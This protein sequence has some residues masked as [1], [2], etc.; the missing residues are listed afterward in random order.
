MLN[1]KNMLWWIISIY[2]SFALVFACAARAGEPVSIDLTAEQVYDDN[3]FRLPGNDY[4][5]TV[6]G[7]GH[8]DDVISRLGV[9]LNWDVPLSLQR[10]TGNAGVVA[11]RFAYNDQLNNDS[12]NM[13]LGW[14][15]EL[16]KAWKGN[17]KWRQEQVLANFS[18]FQDGQRNI[19]T[20]DR[21]E[22]GLTRQIASQWIMLGHWERDTSARSLASQQYN[23]RR[24]VGMRLGITGQSPAGSELKLFITSRTVDYVNWIWI[25]GSAQDDRLREDALGAQLRWSISGTTTAEA[26]ARA[27]QVTNAHLSQNDF[28]GN[29]YDLKLIW[30]DGG[31]MNW[32]A[33]L[34]R[35]ID[36]VESAYA[37][38]V[39]RQ[40]GRLTGQWSTR[41]TWLVRTQMS[42]EWQNHQGGISTS[43]EDTV[44]DISLSL[45]YIAFRSSEFSVLYSESKRDSSTTLGGFRDRTLQLEARAHWE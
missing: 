2:V 43:R 20:Y 22:A 4:S 24:T 29:A 12:L 17:G 11:N 34:W 41:S 19:I 30:D 1:L 37:N 25:P 10:V 42:R 6:V 18:D 38:Y 16:A 7:D 9:Q 14:E 26:G 5:K 28:S 39:L 31:A 35:N 33:A 21:V 23:D 15:G 13:V 3:L 44:V 45:A 32:R 27:E 40:G 8:T 36:V